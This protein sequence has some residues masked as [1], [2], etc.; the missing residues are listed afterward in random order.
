MGELAKFVTHQFT[1][2]MK[3]LIKIFRTTLRQNRWR[4]T[5]TYS[6]LSHAGIDISAS[7]RCTDPGK[8]G[9]LMSDIARLDNS[10]THLAIMFNLWYQTEPDIKQNRSILIPKGKTGH[11]VGNWRPLTLSSVILRLYSKRL[12][13]STFICPRQRGFLA[14]GSTQENI[15]V[16]SRASGFSQGVRF[17][18]SSSHSGRSS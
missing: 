10:D 5:G 1:I 3:W 7:L 17:C 13:K 2:P 4:T 14:E 8:D 15:W 11:D 9:I 16:K 6:T 12:T 18:L